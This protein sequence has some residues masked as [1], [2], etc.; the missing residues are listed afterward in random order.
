MGINDSDDEAGAAGAGDEENLSPTD[1]KI[2]EVLNQKRHEV[3]GVLIDRVGSKN[4]DF[5]NCLNA[6]LILMELTENETLFPFLIETQHISKLITN[7]CDIK[8]QN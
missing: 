1:A 5:E 2:Q 3:I 8:N 4:A 7:S 6:H